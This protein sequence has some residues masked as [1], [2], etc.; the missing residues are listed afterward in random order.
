MAEKMLKFIK[1]E[2]QM[3]AKRAADARATDFEEI[4]SEF[5]RKAAGT[6]F[7]VW[8]PVLPAGLPP[9]EQYSRLA[10]AVG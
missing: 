8:R 1:V 9:L 2:R 10:E 3:P 7:P 6:L 4:Y 5:S